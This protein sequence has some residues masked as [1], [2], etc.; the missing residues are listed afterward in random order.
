MTDQ[1][2][3]FLFITEQ[4]GE[5]NLLKEGIAKD[6]IHFV[7]NV[8]IDTLLHHLQRAESSAILTELDLEPKEFAVLTLHR[9]SNVDAKEPFLEIL[10]ALAEI[11]KRIK[12]IFPIHPRSRQR[13][14]QFGLSG[15]SSEL[16]NLIMTDP[17]GYLDFLRLMSKAKFV[18]TD[19]GGVQEETTVMNIPCLTLRQNTERPVTVSQGSNL[20]I[21]SNADRIVQESMRILNGDFKTGRRPEL[22]DGRAAERIVNVLTRINPVG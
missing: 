11:Q 7:G 9:P 15:R 12:I 6:K 1:I 19:S 22:W 4:S 21:G 5:E 17:L 13:L 10:T 18:L 2:S 20:V 8:M 3:D 14:A 16:P